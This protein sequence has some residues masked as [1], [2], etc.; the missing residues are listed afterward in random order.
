MVVAELV[1]RWLEM[2][3]VEDTLVA[4]ETVE[5]EG[6]REQLALAQMQV[7]S[8]EAAASPLEIFHQLALPES[9]YPLE[10]HTLR[11]ED[12]MENH[13]SFRPAEAPESVCTINLRVT[14]TFTIFYQQLTSKEM[15]LMERY[16]LHKDFH[17]SVR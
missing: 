9:G 17:S 12:P 4:V 8:R 11:M 13:K 7:S 2:S 14:F 6:P 15:D 3:E 5:A 16:L 10:L 1:E